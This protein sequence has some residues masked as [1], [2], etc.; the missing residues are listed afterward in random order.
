MSSTSTPAPDVDALPR[1]GRKPRGGDEF[2]LRFARLDERGHSVGA[3]GPCAAHERG[4]AIGARIRIRV[5]SHRRDELEL[6]TIMM[7][8]SRRSCCRPSG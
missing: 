4:G 5:L 3:C 6:R 7:R 1:G 2:E 8:A